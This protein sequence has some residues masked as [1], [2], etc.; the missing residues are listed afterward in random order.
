MFAAAIFLQLALSPASYFPVE[1]GMEWR[2]EEVDGT[3]TFSV[4]D[5]VRDARTFSV[6]G[7]Q[8][9]LHI[10]ETR[11]GG[12]KA[13]TSYYEIREDGIYLW[14]YEPKAFLETPRPVLKLADAA[15]FPYEGVEM[16]DDGAGKLVFRG[17]AKELGM[18]DVLD[19]QA[20]RL[21]VVINAEITTPSGAVIKNKQTSIY[22]EGIGLVRTV[23]DYEIGKR[24]G[25]RTRTL[26]SFRRAGRDA[27]RG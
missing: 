27:L 25:Q 17:Q 5:I 22:A 6:G 16:L 1:S 14:G 21:Q 18:G 2:Y 19:T 23:D 4:R 20:R 8:K 3:L 10:I 11:V 26:K 12:A 15:T 13:I 24:K 9:P 7:E